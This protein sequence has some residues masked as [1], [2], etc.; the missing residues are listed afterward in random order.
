MPCV[1]FPTVLACLHGQLRLATSIYRQ[2]SLRDTAEDVFGKTHGGFGIPS[3][4]FRVSFAPST[5]K[6]P[7]TF[8]RLKPHGALATW[9]SKEAGNSQRRMIFIV[10]KP[11]GSGELQDEMR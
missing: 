11:L 3:P 8:M 2:L 9:S 4:L 5:A 1:F 7:L 10:G 6:S